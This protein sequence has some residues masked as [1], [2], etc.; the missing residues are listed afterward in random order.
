MR[1]DHPL[2]REITSALESATGSSLAD[3]PCGTDG[4]SIPTYGIA[5]SRLALAFARFGT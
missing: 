4:C 5:L 3:A 2:M 1:P